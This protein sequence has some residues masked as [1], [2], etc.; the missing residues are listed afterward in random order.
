MPRKRKGSPWPEPI[1]DDNFVHRMAMAGV[2]A[3][4]AAGKRAEE[5]REAG[6]SIAEDLELLDAEILAPSQP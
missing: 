2:R 6:L 3:G 1:D 5:R 4:F